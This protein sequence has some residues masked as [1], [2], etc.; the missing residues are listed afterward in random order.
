ML[1]V[2]DLAAAV[3][4]YRDRL[5]FELL[6][7][8]EHIAALRLGSLQLYLFT[9]SP[10]TPDKPGVTLAN[11]NTADQTPVILDLL[12]SDCQEAYERLLGSGVE[13]L[14]PP[15]TPP[16]GGRRCFARDPDGYLIEL[17]QNPESPFG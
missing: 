1:V 3:A 10:P 9:Y 13:F 12:V 15:H 5:G 4:F 16:W 17:E 14:S 11:L 6:R 2:C 7:Q 8:E